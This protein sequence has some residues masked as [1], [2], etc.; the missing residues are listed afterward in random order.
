M[1][2]ISIYSLKCKS[3]S[4]IKWCFIGRCCMVTCLL[5]LD[6]VMLCE[7]KAVQD[8]DLLFGR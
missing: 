6:P 8:D 3:V 5:Q 4:G 7:W 2:K 1:V